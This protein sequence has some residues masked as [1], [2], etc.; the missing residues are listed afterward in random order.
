MPR[1][2]VSVERK[3]QI[4]EAA[5][6]VFDRQGF[7][8]TRMKDI[9]AEAGLSVGILYH[10]FAD[11]ESLLEALLEHLFVT[12]LQTTARAFQCGKS[13]RECLW[14]YFEQHLLA[15]MRF[16]NAGLELR[17]AAA[18]HPHLRARLLVFEKEYF[19][20]LLSLIE[21]GMSSGELRPAPPEII[22]LTLLSLYDGLLENLPRLLPESQEA[23]RRE[24]IRQ[25]FDL[26]FQGLLA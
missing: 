9:A 6:R 7:A 8:Q 13:V 3:A 1:P 25:A 23:A 26:V 5:L 14:E 24:R 18:R 17:A 11:K 22:A 16:L 10:Y 12:D 2:D 4:L 15:E 19:D 21:R 20:L